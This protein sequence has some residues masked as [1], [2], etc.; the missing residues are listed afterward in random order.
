M[1]TR[2]LFVTTALA[3]LLA[4][5]GLAQETGTVGGDAE[6]TGGAALQ[7]YLVGDLV[8]LPVES[9]DGTEVGRVEAVVGGDTAAQILVGLQDR[10]VALPL[11]TVTLSET[12]MALRV[13]RQT[14]ELEQMAAYDGAAE[15]VLD[16]GMMVSEAIAEHG[17]E[18][19]AS[20]RGTD[21]TAT[22]SGD[23]ILTA[24]PVSELA[25]T[26]TDPAT[27][28]DETQT[29][30][31]S[32]GTLTPGTGTD[33]ATDMAQA[34]EAVTDQ[35]VA[36]SDMAETDISGAGTPAM[37]PA[38]AGASTSFAGMT[39]GEALGMTVVDA[40]GE[41]VGDID[42]IYRDGA[43]AYMAVIG[44]GGFLGI[45]E[46]TVAVSLGDFSIDTERN[47]LILD[48]TEDELRS[49][50]DIDEAGLEGLPDDHLID[51]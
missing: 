18:T 6:A 9:S 7:S 48:R 31:G 30:Q 47:A 40:A 50:P 36:T 34:D 42:Y 14:A 5:P 29:A 25:E 26:G 22:D 39:V 10:T 3:A 44:I 4:G 24:E 33:D 8:G 28:G 37:D 21:A 45:G 20:A 17:S 43:G 27:L 41:T 15:T 35:N 38:N 32:D 16:P 19:T 13:E 1:K 46:H 2:N 51:A 12:G 49:M 11:E 23:G